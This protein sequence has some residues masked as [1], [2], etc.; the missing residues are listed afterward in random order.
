M[1]VRQGYFYVFLQF[2]GQ[3]FGYFT[4]YICRFTKKKHVQRKYVQTRKQGVPGVLRSFLVYY[5][6]NLPFWKITFDL[7]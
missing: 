7:A 6:N 5:V 4:N 1:F 2:N 3:N